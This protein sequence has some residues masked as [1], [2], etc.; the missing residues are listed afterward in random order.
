MGMYVLCVLCTM[1][2]Y[3]VQKV[4]LPLNNERAGNR[5]FLIWAH[6]ILARLEFV[7]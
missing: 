3:C 4:P 5:L 7:I 1:T 2:I 6:F